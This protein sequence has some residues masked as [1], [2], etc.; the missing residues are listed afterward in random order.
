MSHRNH[1]LNVSHALA[2]NFLLGN[3]YTATVANNTFVTN[4]F[5]FTAMALVIFYRA[6]NAFT[7][8][9]VAFGL[10][11]TVVDRFWFQHF[12]AGLFEDFLGRS[13]AYRDF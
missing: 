4:A 2:A 5:V 7:K 3:F 10:V 11:S 12:T 6:E 8:E 13:Q 9:T 1:E